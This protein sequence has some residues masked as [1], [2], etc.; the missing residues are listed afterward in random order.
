MKTVLETRQAWMRGLFPGGIPRLWCPL[1]T[2]Y[3]P[4]GAIDFGRMEAH[5]DAIAPSIGG[6]LVPGSTG[7]GW[8]LDEEETLRVTE[9]ALD[10]ARRRGSRLLI[11]VLRGK[12]EDVLRTL[13][14]LLKLTGRPKDGG[15]EEATARAWGDRG[16][17]GF[18][19]CPPAGNTLTQEDIEAGLTAILDQGL[20]TALYQLPQVTESE[21]APETFAR[22]VA[23]YP[24][25]VFFKDSSGFD[26]IAASDVD[27]GGVFLVRGAEGDYARW[28]READGLY[29]GFLLST[30]NCFPGKLSEVVK[31]METGNEREAVMLSR[32]LTETI[33]GV[34]SLVRNLRQGNAFTN[35]NKAMD[36]FLAFGPEADIGRG[37]VLHSKERIPGN[38]LAATREVLRRQ[39]LLPLKGYLG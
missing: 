7:D 1:L 6:Y 8:E 35:A 23:K 30:A 15:G 11:G 33:N 16:V 28:L 9:F 36:H 34:F 37:P 17:A 13:S 10:Q 31:N 26:R 21:A 5:L 24:R 27:K 32:R 19:I 39:A 2:H 25:I 22:L 20:P 3:G 29:D 4:D 18:T 38:I 14:G 12:T